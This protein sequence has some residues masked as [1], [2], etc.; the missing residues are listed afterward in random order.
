MVALAKV[1]EPEVLPGDPVAGVDGYGF[2]DECFSLLYFV[3]GESDKA[4]VVVVVGDDA[5][6]GDGVAAS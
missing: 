3:A 6:V 4:G 2:V 1:V 5:L